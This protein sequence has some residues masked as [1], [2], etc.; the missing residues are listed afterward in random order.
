MVAKIPLHFRS[1]APGFIQS[2]TYVDVATGTLFL[3]LYAGDVY[4]LSKVLSSTAW[5]SDIG[6][7]P[8]GDNA[9]GDDDFDVLIQKNLTVEGDAIVMVP[10]GLVAGNT[11]PLTVGTTVTAR[12]RTWD[13]SSETTIASGTSAKSHT[14]QQNSMLQKVYAIKLTL[15]K[16]TIKA[17]TYLRLTIETSAPGADREIL[18]IHDPNNR[19]NFSVSDNNSL[20]ASLGS[21]A[22]PTSLILNLPIKTQ[23]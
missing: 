14:V 22:V 11:G 21:F 6:I 17:G 15:P 16:T 23:I 3:T 20:G 5:Y 2:Y 12:I 4:N 1:I 7:T 19:T 10:I 18:L 9:A 13:G 8:A